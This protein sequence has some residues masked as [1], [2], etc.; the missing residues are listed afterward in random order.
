[1]FLHYGGGEIA[2]FRQVVADAGNLPISL[3]YFNLMR[4]D[5]KIPEYSGSMLLDSGA[6]SVSK[7]DALFESSV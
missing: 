3:S 1:M 2:K 5:K 7:S 4:N 6:M